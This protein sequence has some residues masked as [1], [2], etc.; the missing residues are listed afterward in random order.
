MGARQR[1]QEHETQ[2]ARLTELNAAMERDVQ[3][4]NERNRLM[5]DVRRLSHPHG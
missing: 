5:A 4:M 2:L 1:V 3:K